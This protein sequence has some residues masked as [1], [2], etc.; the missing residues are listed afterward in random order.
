MLYFIFFTIYLNISHI[1]NR[2]NL[3]F[4]LVRETRLLFGTMGED[5]NETGKEQ[6]LNLKKRTRLGK[7]SAYFYLGR[8]CKI[9][10][11]NHMKKEHT[12]QPITEESFFSES[13][14]TINSLQVSE[15]LVAP[16][17]LEQNKTS[18]SAHLRLG[19]HLM[20]W[21]TLIGKCL[22]VVLNLWKSGF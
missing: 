14:S 1:Q 8:R 15:I 5:E 21:I 13:S 9:L 4:L 10:M 22:E 3:I 6:M 20:V 17:Y 19:Q 12:R 11:L 2:Y 16:L 7:Q 18:T